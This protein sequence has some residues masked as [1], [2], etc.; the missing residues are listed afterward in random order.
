MVITKFKIELILMRHHQNYW[1]CMGTEKLKNCK[2]WH[3]ENMHLKDRSPILSFQNR[4][5][6]L[7]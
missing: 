4:L 2:N 5:M 3:T 6:K 7:K 1:S